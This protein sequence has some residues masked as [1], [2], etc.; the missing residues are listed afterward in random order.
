MNG[1]GGAF[2]AGSVVGKMV[3]DRTKWAQS[4]E[5]VKGDERSLRGFSERTTKRLQ[6][7]GTAMTL[8][9]GIIVGALGGMIKVASDAEETYAKFGTVFKDV[10][11][12]AENAA[13]NLAESYGVST[14]A[15]K[16]MLGA[17][18]DL[19]TGLGVMPGV[20]L[21]LS[22]KTQQLAID[23][24]SFTNFS[25]GATGASD[26]LTKAM[27]GERESIKSLGI[28]ITEEMVKERLLSEGKGKLTGLAQKQA[29]AEA[30][31]A[32]AYEQSKNAV[33]D[34]ART[35]DSFANQSRL[36][37]ARLQD[38]AVTLGTQLLPVATQIVTGITKVVAKVKE[39]TEAHPQL[40]ERLVKIAAV[41][42][43]V[44]L[45][46][47]PMLIMLPK[48]VRGF[49]SVGKVIKGVSDITN[50]LKKIN[51]LSL[52]PIALVVAALAGLA[53][54][55]MKVKEA[56]KKA[57]E[58][59]ERYDVAN[60]NLFKK[61]EKSATAAGMTKGE[62]TK[63]RIEYD[64]NSAALAMA[65]KRGKE[66]KELQESLA[67][68][69]KEH[70][71]EIKNQKDALGD[72]GGAFNNVT[73]AGKEWLEYLKNVG[74]L[75]TEQKRSKADEL[76]GVIDNLNKAY[77][78][79]KL[80]LTDWTTAVK[81]AN[82]EIA[83]LTSTEAITLDQQRD[84]AA[85]LR[86]LPPL[87][88][89]YTYAMQTGEERVRDWA[90]ANHIGFE[91]AQRGMYDLTSTMMK[92]A[93]IVMPELPKAAEDAWPQMKKAADKTQTAWTEASQYIKDQ[94]TMGLK[95]MLMGA[96]SFRD[97][98]KGIWGSI[99]EQFFTLVAQMISKWT[100]GFIGNLISSTA[101]GATDAIGTLGDVGK[102]LIDGVKDV[103]KK[104]LDVAK[105]FSPG[106]IAQGVITGAVS[107]L[108]S[109][110]VGG[111]FPKASQN[112]LKDLV[113]NSNNIL[114]TLRLDFRDAQ[115]NRMLGHMS[116]SQR[117]LFEIQARADRRNQLLTKS[118]D[119][120]S[121]I[122][123]RSEGILNAIK[124]VTSASNGAVLNS[125]QLVMAHGTPSNPEIIARQSALQNVMRQQQLQ[126]QINMQLQQKVEMRGLMITDRDYTR[127]RMMPEIL[128]ALENDGRFKDRMKRI[129][130]T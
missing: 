86:Q 117:H 24:A 99:K 114:A 27:L 106:G 40:T 8:T 95:D 18:G 5:K 63:L 61:L 97:V 38:V 3:L 69:G 34:Y 85:I 25:G 110:L 94:W 17:T 32:I 60:A 14:M 54:G 56:Q 55:Y 46:L 130:L 59:A 36:L 37:K 102:N 91:E 87:V 7:L 30:T 22:E 57:R 2:L 71:A 90:K 83:K 62:F 115:Y 58:A 129:L 9:G 127:Q 53:Y 13:E 89:G 41:V 76:Y 105:G 123:K 118:E 80:N 11:G 88:Q 49:E 92:F 82:G 33:G 98:A 1:M 12:A 48:L 78:D 120:L 45:A 67:K 68:V 121:V 23:L 39:W 21:D 43:T 113:Q 52:G 116:E 104:V 65:I 44:M 75:T 84:G 6:G 119:Y 72:L 126:Q 107:G 100:I 74:I 50:K 26:A 77:A 10:S 20:A 4:I 70:A 42:G 29:A 96:K 16:D 19:L 124:S 47:G 64:N 128:A 79:G 66:S 28:V 15:A 109:G 111:G 31:L 108:V 103:G 125:T 51:L 112:H 122:A 101:K 93:G 73:T 81:K 35:S